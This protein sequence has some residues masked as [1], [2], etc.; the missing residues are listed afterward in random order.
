MATREEFAMYVQDQL[1]LAGTITLKKMFG[2]YGIYCNE[3]FIGTICDNQLFLKMTEGA[4]KLLKEVKEVPPY[5]GAKPS[6]L[7]E[8]LEDTAYLAKIVQATYEEL[9]MPKPKVKK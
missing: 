1:S 7:I 4:K 3:K 9:P 5:Q 2:E 6:F 8:E